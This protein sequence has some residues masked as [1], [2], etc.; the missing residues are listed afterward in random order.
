MVRT[1]PSPFDRA[2]EAF[3]ALLEVELEL[4]VDG[5]RIGAGLPARPIA[6]GELRRL[7]LDRKVGFAARDAVLAEV[8][9]R[10]QA[11][12]GPWRTA[13]IGLLLPGLRRAAGRLARTY[14][15]DRD[16]LDAEILVGLLEEVAE[17]PPERER[18]AA[19][20]I[21][22]AVRRGLA[23]KGDEASRAGRQ[24]PLE[25]SVAPPPPW[26][27]HPDLVLA[28]AVEAGVVSYHEAALIGASRLERIPLSLLGAHW[29]VAPRTLAQRRLRG[30]R[31]LV[32]WICADSGT[33]LSRNGGREA[34]GGVRADGRGTGSGR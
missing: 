22:A 28:Q 26:G 25:G 9:R 5:A 11:G 13:L 27:R 33:G 1:E 3:E 14:R 21:W 30:E 4:V 19:S 32:A 7:L 34:V 16:D 24:V 12:S 23:F 18:L 2:E 15:G 31:R 6:L 17:V 10:A 20:L 29:G 8:V